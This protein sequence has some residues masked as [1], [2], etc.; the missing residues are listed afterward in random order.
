MLFLQALFMIYR[1]KKSD[2]GIFVSNDLYN[3]TLS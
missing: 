3:Y 1:N 2:V